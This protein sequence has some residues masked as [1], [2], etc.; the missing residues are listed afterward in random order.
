MFRRYAGAERLEGVVLTPHVQSSYAWKPSPSCNASGVPGRCLSLVMLQLFLA[1]SVMYAMGESILAVDLQDTH[2]ADA[3]L[4]RDFINLT[5]PS[6]SSDRQPCSLSWQV[7]AAQQRVAVQVQRGV[8]ARL[9]Q[10]QRRAV[11]KSAHVSSKWLTSR[12]AMSSGVSS[13]P[14]RG[15]AVSAVPASSSSPFSVSGTSSMSS[16]ASARP[17]QPAAS[18]G[19]P[20]G[21][22]VSRSD[23]SMA[24]L[25]QDSLPK[26]KATRASWLANHQEL[27]DA[28]RVDSVEFVDLYTGLVL[29]LLL[30]VAA[31]VY[32]AV[33][34]AALPGLAVLK[35]YMTAGMKRPTKSIER[36]AGFQV[37]A[38][39]LAVLALPCH[40]IVLVYWLAIFPTI[41]IL[42]LLYSLASLKILLLRDNLALMQS[43]SRWPKWSWRD[44]VCAV[45]GTMDR[46]GFAKFAFKFP[47]AMVLAPIL[48]YLFGCNPLLYRLA[49]RQRCLWTSPLDFNDQKAVAAVVQAASWTLVNLTDLLPQQVSKPP[50]KDDRIVSGHIP[51]PAPDRL[52]GTVV[53]VLTTNSLVTLVNADHNV[54]GSI[55]H[56]MTAKRSIYNVLLFVWNPCHY[57]TG[58]V[59][60]NLQHD[61]G[62]EQAST[63][64][65]VESNE[66]DLCTNSASCFAAVWCLVGDNYLGNLLFERTDALFW[67]YDP[68]KRGQMGPCSVRFIR[69][70]VASTMSVTDSVV[71]LDGSNNNDDRRAVN[72][73]EVSLDSY[74]TGESL[75]SYETELSLGSCDSALNDDVNDCSNR[76]TIGIPS[77]S[78]TSTGEVEPIPED[79]I[80]MDSVA[81][82]QSASSSASQ[83]DLIHIF[84]VKSAVP[85]MKRVAH[86]PSL[87]LGDSPLTR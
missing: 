87:Q 5:S 74:K 10:I 68:I 54:N 38:V 15:S 9:T 69:G 52:S 76:V 1:G 56:S 67:H 48:K 20:W 59:E 26:T 81:M 70:S 37:V 33:G 39:V 84:L 55:F 6:S 65:R 83:S 46:Q 36:G 50:R 27:D 21:D 45:L 24:K 16:A 40:V 32:V 86:V 29:L 30:P 60:I 2:P 64:S 85:S 72:D 4:L 78:F 44:I 63:L 75:E 13:V 61:G 12:S 79:R 14:V 66:S 71:A 47:S 58:Y 17:A 82:L 73:T 8:G 25:L 42:S 11:P 62:I 22:F 53:G 57:L 35:I 49:I 23:A 41:F 80:T 51:F 31:V 3:G 34:L 77:N 43:C 28:D 7:A 19:G 18:V